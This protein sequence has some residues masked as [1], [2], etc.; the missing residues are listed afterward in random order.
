MKEKDKYQGLERVLTE[1]LNT[2]AEEDGFFEEEPVEDE[3]ISNVGELDGLQVEVKAK[4][5]ADALLKGE[6]IKKLF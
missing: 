3:F 2:L 4:L 5:I 1:A 6:R